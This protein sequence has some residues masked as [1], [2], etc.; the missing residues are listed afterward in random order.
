MA[1]R[2]ILTMLLCCAATA[3]ASPRS[4]PTVGRA[5]F[6][7][8]TL[9]N[10]TSIGLNP[11]ALGLGT[12]GEVF[13]ALTGV[14]DQIGIAR[15]QLDPATGALTPGAKI[16]TTEASPGGM[17]GLVVHAG[18][19]YT[20]GIQAYSPPRE[21]FVGG[22]DALR[23]H[24]LGGGQRDWIATISGS[25]KITSKIYFGASLSHDNT[26]F[27][28]RYARDTALA[29]GTGPGGVASDCGAPCGIENPE[30]SE[31]Y[32]VDVRSPLLSTSN[33]KLNVGL[34]AQLWSG[35][36]LGLAYHTPPGFDIQTQL[37][38]DLSVTR[39]P[40]DGGALLTGG[41]TVYVSY[42][43]SVDGELRARLPRLIDLHI[44]GRWED[45][46]RMQ[47]YDVR[48]YN[49][50]FAANGIPEWMLRARGLHDAFSMWAGLEQVDTGQPFRFG[51]RIGF[52]TSSLDAANTSALTISP[53]SLTADA[54][55]Q[56][57]IAASWLVQLSYGF[58]YFPR[59]AVDKSAFDPRDPRDCFAHGL[60]YST[61]ACRAVRDGFALPTAAGDYTRFQH[62]MRIGLRYEL[63]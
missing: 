7:G 51:G 12:T 24:T 40:R 26:F 28:L 34:V 38:G 55:V 50:T 30:A 33:V 42:P 9:P 49:S 14:V 47:A 56:V 48:A 10:A 25:F 32:D 57:R 1:A 21:R 22:Y 23:Y 3:H 58:A 36:W 46:S 27:R 60:A 39:A 37:R 44:G 20:V 52:E 62:A 35:V 45:L 13:V 29:N 63:P 59:V 4:D 19:S 53:A 43:A 5:V 18:E 2:P 15:K 11:A 41:S 17:V 61:R 31:L 16:S 6:T 54:G 8:A